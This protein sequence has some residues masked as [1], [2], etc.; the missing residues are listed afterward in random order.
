MYLNF[1]K[2]LFTHV[3]KTQIKKN[4]KYCQANNCL[5]YKFVYLWKKYQV[6]PGRIRSLWEHRLPLLFKKWSIPRRYA[7]SKYTSLSKF[8]RGREDHNMPD[9]HK[10]PHKCILKTSQNFQKAFLKISEDSQKNNFH[11]S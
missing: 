11:S 2:I 1:K 8:K 10:Q 3:Y 4:W 9:I 7:S 5:C 6:T